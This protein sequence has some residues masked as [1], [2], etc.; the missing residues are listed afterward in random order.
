MREVALD[1]ETTG[2]DPAAGHRIVE[3]AAVEMVNQL[4]TGESFHRLINPEREIDAEAIA[5]HGHTTDS[6]RDAP[7]FAILAGEFLT[8][9]GD[10]P[11]VAHNA[12]FDRAFINAEFSKLGLEIL[13]AERFVDSLALARGKFPGKANTLDAL[14]DRFKIN[15]ARRVKHGALTDA[16]LLAEVYCELRGGRQGALLLVQDKKPDAAGAYLANRPRRQV[17]I[18]SAEAAAHALFVK[19]LGKGAIWSAY[20]AAG[21]AV[22]AAAA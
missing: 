21:V 3:I 19:R 16:E 7:T 15:R 13:S 17:V 12:E 9:I 5:I 22:E 2:L 11:L 20:L 10:A 8:F 1:T 14:C 18:D 6:L 4:A